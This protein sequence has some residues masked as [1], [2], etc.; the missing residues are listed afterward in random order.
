MY[1]SD[2]LIRLLLPMNAR[3]AEADRQPTL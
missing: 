2:G 1:S 3:H